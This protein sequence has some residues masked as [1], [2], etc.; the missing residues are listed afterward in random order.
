MACLLFAQQQDFP[1]NIVWD[2]Y[3]ECIL[4]IEPGW[5]PGTSSSIAQSAELKTSK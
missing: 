2:G 4:F 5:T 1:K 3:K